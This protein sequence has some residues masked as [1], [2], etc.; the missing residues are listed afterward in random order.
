MHIFRLDLL[1]VRSRGNTLRTLVQAL[2]EA[3]HTIILELAASFSS[4]GKS[5]DRVIRFD[6]RFDDEGRFGRS[7][8]M[9][10]LWVFGHLD[11]DC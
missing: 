4:Y 5:S 3:R 10:V 8:P 9:F 7:A 6:I 11:D 2:E 1:S